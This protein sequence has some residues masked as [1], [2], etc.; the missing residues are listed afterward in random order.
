M[1]LNV[2]G[3]RRG[4]TLV[5]LLV[6]IAI[7]GILVALLLPAVQAAREAARRM[8]CSNN[9]KQI[10]LALHNYHD[11]NRKFPP[12]FIK[13]YGRGD[14]R[15]RRGNWSWG[16]FIL[17]Y[18]ELK[19]LSERLE[20]GPARLK[21]AIM[22]PMKRAAMRQIL[23]TFRCPSD[24]GPVNNTGRRIAGP[25]NAA[26]A[27]SNY[28]AVNDTRGY[29]RWN[30]NGSNVR[31][32]LFGRNRARRMR[33]IR[34]GTSNTLAIGERNWS[35]VFTDGRVRNVL[36]GVVF[37]IRGQRR[38]S[39]WGMADAMGSCR[40]RINFNYALQSPLS[41]SRR[42][43]G[44]PHPGGAQFALCDGSVRFIS[45]NIDGDMK[46]NQQTKTTFPNSTWENLCAIADRHPLGPF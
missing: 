44:S 14:A 13:I 40:F 19:P 24:N 46:P 31:A 11:S 5:E 25:P 12:G 22:V 2:V 27:T 36:A 29:L 39:S 18:L 4:F 43:F 16:A 17:P 37:G 15:D 3:R 7:I 34:D 42:G 28:I 8:S 6:V 41:R 35:R 33:D 23:A 45:Q 9:L 10:G 26:L 38:T 1:R 30:T 20:V 32:G 21:E